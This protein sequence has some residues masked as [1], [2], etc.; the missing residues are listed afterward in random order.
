VPENNCNITAYVSPDV[1]KFDEESISHGA[2]GC[3]FNRNDS[4][5]CPVEIG[6]DFMVN[7][8]SPFEGPVTDSDCHKS[9]K[10]N[11]ELGS[12]CLDYNLTIHAQGDIGLN[13]TRARQI[14]RDP[15]VSINVADN[16]RCV[17][18]SITTAYWN[19]QFGKASQIMIWAIGAAVVGILG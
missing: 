8:L 5:F 6:D 16:D 9:S 18:E 17:A 13:Y 4:S 14:F 2:A 10:L 7:S 19:H 12:L 3:G 15:Q 1:A 11:A